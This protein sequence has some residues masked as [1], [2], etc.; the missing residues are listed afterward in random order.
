MNDIWLT[1]RTTNLTLHTEWSM[2]Y[3]LETADRHQAE[4]T[5]QAPPQASLIS[6]AAPPG[7]PAYDHQ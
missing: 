4:D 2:S 1:V 7:L 3:E 5:P 6:C